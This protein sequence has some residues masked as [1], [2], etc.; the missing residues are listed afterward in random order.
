MNIT[1]YSVVIIKMKTNPTATL[2]VKAKMKFPV[3]EIL[4]SEERTRTYDDFFNLIQGRIFWLLKVTICSTYHQCTAV[5]Q[6]A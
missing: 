2:D 4:L 1:T 5:Y 6:I 3:K